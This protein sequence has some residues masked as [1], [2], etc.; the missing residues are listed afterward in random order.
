MGEGKGKDGRVGTPIRAI[1]LEIK[2]IG[3]LHNEESPL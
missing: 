3:F 1:V 2:Y